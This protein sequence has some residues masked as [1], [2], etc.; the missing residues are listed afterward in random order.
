MVS[1]S[2]LREGAEGGMWALGPSPGT[3]RFGHSEQPA[4][5][6]AQGDAFLPSSLGSW[7]S[8][9]P[10][11][12]SPVFLIKETVKH[13]QFFFRSQQALG[14]PRGRR[15]RGEETGGNSPCKTWLW[16]NSFQLPWN[17]IFF[18]TQICHQSHSWK[19]MSS[20]P[21]LTVGVIIPFQESHCWLLGASCLLKA[22]FHLLRETGVLGTSALGDPTDILLSWF[23]RESDLLSSCYL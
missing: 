16:L 18:W 11:F 4:N 2:F 12:P 5:Q 1:G 7:T 6:G 10:G 9:E 13:C 20:S 15:R 21:I 23:R 22:F 3:H 17:P 8:P 19:P 14:C